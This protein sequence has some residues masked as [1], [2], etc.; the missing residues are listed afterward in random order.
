M[1]MKKVREKQNNESKNRKEIITIVK[2]RGQQQFEIK[3]I[4]EDKETRHASKMWRKSG[5]NFENWV[6]S[7]K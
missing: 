3:Q 1:N 2:V 7:G 4:E 5:Q 6:V